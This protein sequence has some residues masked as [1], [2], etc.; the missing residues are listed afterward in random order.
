MNSFRVMH[1]AVKVGGYIY[2]SVPM[3]GFLDHGYV[4]YNP[5][6]FIE[7]AGANRYRVVAMSINGPSGSESVIDILVREYAGRK[8]LDLP[9]VVAQKWAGLSVPTSSLS[10]LL[11]KTVDQPFRVSL[12]VSTT[13]GSAS[14]QVASATTY[15]HEVEQEEAALLSRIDDIALTPEE[16]FGVFERHSVAMPHRRF[17]ILLERKCLQLFLARVPNGTIFAVVWAKVETEMLA[18]T[19][20]LNFKPVENGIDRSLIRLDGREDA[21]L[22]LTPEPLR[23][24]HA[25]AAYHRYAEV[26]RLASFPLELEIAGLAAC[27]GGR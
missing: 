8:L 13:V 3:T 22:A 25:I 10:V 24:A 27:Y 21:I 23:F 2:H 6:L 12:E 1:D 4:N 18:D 20:L 11:E 26:G 16:I 15:E 5:R 17:P 9:E 14:G 19:P 7:L